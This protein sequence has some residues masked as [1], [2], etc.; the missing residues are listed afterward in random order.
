M[1]VT[2]GGLR[3]APWRIRLVGTVVGVEP[4]DKTGCRLVFAAAAVPVAATDE[5]HEP[6]SRKGGAS[7]PVRGRLR[8]AAHIGRG[9]ESCSPAT[10]FPIRQFCQLWRAE[11]CAP[12]RLRR[13]FA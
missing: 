1:L 10:R 8:P 11:P 6:L 4:G 9:L 5:P 2:G 12:R 13:A 3:R 7:R